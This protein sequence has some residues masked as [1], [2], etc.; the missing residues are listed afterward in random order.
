VEFRSSR[1]RVRQLV[2]EELAPCCEYILE[3]YCISLLYGSTHSAKDG[4]CYNW[5]RQ[6]PCEPQF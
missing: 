1:W 6:G 3:V 2:I 4:I 5:R